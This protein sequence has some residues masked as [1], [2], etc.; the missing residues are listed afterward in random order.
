M[1][2]NR[3]L[4]L[5]DLYRDSLYTDILPFWLK[6]GVDREHGGYFTALDRDGT[7]LDSDK[8][9]WF[10]GR[11]SWIL[12]TLQR[13]EGTAGEWSSL[14]ESGLQFLDQHCID[15]E[16]GLM[17]FQV[18]SD[19]RPIRKRR[20]RFSEAFA[21]LAHAAFYQL[22]G[23]ES[24]ADR[25]VRCFEIFES[26]A[27]NPELSPF[28]PKFTGTRPSKSIGNPMFVLHLAQ[29]CREAQIPGIDWTSH[30]DSSIAEIASDFVHSDIT[31]V[32][33]TV[34]A[35]G[36]R[37]D[38]HFDGQTLNPG[39]AIEAAWFILQEAKVRGNSPEWIDLGTRML[40]WMWDRGWDKELGGLLYFV[41]VDER[42]VQEYWHDMKFWWPQNEAE[43]ATLLAYQ[44]T[45]KDHYLEMHSQVHEWSW[46]HFPDAE[47]GEW[48]GYLHR[49]GSLSSKV[50]GTMWK[51]PYHIP[52]MMMTC[53]QICDEIISNQSVEQV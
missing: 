50:K 3:F 9:V 35:D 44:L 51:G 39:H 8:N 24:H 40:D 28:P 19:G 13:S 33:E 21:T 48:F 31:C 2:T 16:D 23:A 22:T 20:Y 53:Q 30:I 26:H 32:M 47:F 49:D 10:Q 5:R 4:L 46:S 29:V 25:A 36:S 11:F 34:A 18:T 12:S 27:R 38:D 1:K 17:W 7:L 15:P 14:A 42:P 43:I 6:H 45:G 52:R 41:G 37:I